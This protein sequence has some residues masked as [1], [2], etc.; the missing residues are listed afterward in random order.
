MAVESTALSL[1]TAPPSSVPGI[2][3]MNLNGPKSV[4]S[5]AVDNNHNIFFSDPIGGAVYFMNARGQS[6]PI[7]KFL[8][9]SS[10]PMVHAYPSGL[11]FDKGR[12]RLYV[13][14]P[15]LGYI[16]AYKISY[17]GATPI[18][19]TELKTIQ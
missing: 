10:S 17:N 18:S 15:T 9:N 3:G 7:T 12:N 2:F 6:F 19:A 8:S 16:K 13:S 5:T 4:F 14:Y 1:R 11:A